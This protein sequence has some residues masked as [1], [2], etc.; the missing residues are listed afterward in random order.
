MRTKDAVAGVPIARVLQG[1]ITR[2]VIKQ[3]V[4]TTSYGVTA[5][6][7][8]EQIGR[9]LKDAGTVPKERIFE[10]REYLQ[11]KVFEALDNM[12][13]VSKHI[14]QWFS[15]NAYN[16]SILRQQPVRWTTPLGFS[17]VQPYFQKPSKG[18]RSYSIFDQPK[19]LKQK[20]AFPPNFV[21]SLDAVHMMLTALHCNR[22]GITFASVHDCYWTHPCDVDIMNRICREQFIAL[23]QLPILKNLSDE[24]KRN[25]GFEEHEIS[26]V[27]R[28][29]VER[30]HEALEQLPP[31]TVL[32]SGSS[33][34]ECEENNTASIVGSE[35]LP[36]DVSFDEVRA[37]P[38]W[39]DSADS[40]ERAKQLLGLNE[41]LDQVP[42]QGNFDIK[43]VLKSTYFFA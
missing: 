41:L 33:A 26:R 4:M 43:N 39:N 22:A 42:P 14:K 24:F 23:H 29:H 13:I 20:T 25:Y 6:G 31:T 18:Q 11:H 27:S 38:F 12:F 16:I 32:A 15:D 21:H 28:P 1:C 37:L 2:K 10:A 36:I 30:F 3:T 40:E 34:T 5:Y 17:V 7:A 35:D 19:A 9:Q 8:R